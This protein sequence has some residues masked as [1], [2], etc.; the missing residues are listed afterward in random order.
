MRTHP[1]SNA[2]G[3]AFVKACS[4]AIF[5]GVAHCVKQESSLAA[6]IRQNLHPSPSVVNNTLHTTKLM[7][8][9][10]SGGKA[11]NSGCKFANF[12]LIIDGN[13]NNEISV[14]NCFKTFVAHMR[15][16]FPAGK[17][18]DS[19]F[20]VLADGSFFN[21]YP[22]IAE[23]F[24]IIEEAITVCGANDKS[25]NAAS[26]KDLRAETALSGNSKKSTKRN[27]DAAAASVENSTG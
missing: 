16:K 20:K 13:L 18:G 23:C 17:G 24:R 8:N 2:P 1:E 27:P 7:V 6:S 3:K 26:Q 22:T 21:A 4:E 10:L 25:E 12:Y 14:V 5:F 11:V 9:L 19:A 15:S